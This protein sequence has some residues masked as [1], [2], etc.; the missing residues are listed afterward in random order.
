MVVT[1]EARTPVQPRASGGATQPEAAPDVKAD[2]YLYL[3]GRP[4]LRDMLHFARS[5]AVTPPDEADL[6]ARWQAAH[7][8]IRRLETEEAGIA[9]GPPMGKLGPEYEPLLLELLEDPLVQ[10][11]FNTV[12]TDVALV[13]LDRLVV[14]Q[15][16][17]DL[18]YVRQLA[19]WLGP[20]L[21]DATI[22]RTCLLHDHDEPPVK[23][24]RAHHDTFVFISPSN[25]LRFL[26][27]VPLQGDQIKDYPAR[28]KFLGV[29]GLAVG[30]GSNFLNA[31]YAERRLVLNNG[32]HRAYALR[33][34][35]V[36]HVPCII[37]HAASRDEVDAVAAAE[38]RKN[39]DTYL[40]HPRP[41]MLKDY[42]D[43]Q[44]HLVMP[45]YRRLRQITVRFEIEENALPAL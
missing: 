13:E 34:L 4:R 12:P 17:I 40:K 31:I 20:T 3:T 43:P 29:V 25:D 42:F 7:E 6:A 18:T 36:T 15:K 1:R 14:Y 11:G 39:P 33:M 38:V 32:S 8:R 45:V 27:A 10:N 9:D 37:Q 16:H 26:G 5:H 23:W 21:S 30:L 2:E 28:G 19:S 35:G 24:S 44:L 41:S 22:F